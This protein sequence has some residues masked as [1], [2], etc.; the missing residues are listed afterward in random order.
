VIWSPISRTI[1]EIPTANLG[2]STTVSLIKVLPSNWETDNRKWQ[3]VCRLSVVAAIAWHVHFLWAGE[4]PGS[5]FSET[6]FSSSSS[7]TLGWNEPSQ[8]V[9]KSCHWSVASKN[10][11]CSEL[12]VVPQPQLNTRNSSSADVVSL[13]TAAKI[14]FVYTEIPIVFLI[15]WEATFCYEIQYTWTARSTETET[16]T[17][18]DRYV[19]LGARWLT[20]Y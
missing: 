10:L 15:N 11:F 1:T 9:I 7:I 13:C 20:E 6:Y 5:G 4:T 19:M 2:F 3:R 17:G 8:D 14:L 18:L 16:E 12:H